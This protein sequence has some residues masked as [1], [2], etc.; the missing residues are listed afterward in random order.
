MLSKEK[1]AQVVEKFIAGTDKFLVDIKVSST[2]VIDVF[3][4]GDQGISISECVKITR[5]LEKTFD[6]DQ[7]D[8]ELHVSSPGLTKPF[9]LRRQYQKYINRDIKLVTIDDE[10]K[11]GTLKSVND[12]E[13]EL[14][15]KV[16]KKGKEIKLEKL[17]FENIKEAKPVISFK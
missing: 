10:K 16:G 7:E 1:I 13:I 6:R 4:D 15:Q 2:N 11:Q 5:H 9:V 8:Y 14:E 12:D 3:V 17:L